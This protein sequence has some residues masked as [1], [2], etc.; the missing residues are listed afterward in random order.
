MADPALRLQR[1]AVI[2]ASGLIGR[3]LTQAL[4]RQGVEV[5][6]T[7]FSHANRDAVR[8]DISDREA[9]RRFFDQVQPQ[10][11]FLAVNTPGGVD[12]CETDFTLAERVHVLGTRN[13]AEAAAHA[14]AKTVFYSTDYIFNGQSGPYTEEA[15]P[16]PIS[17][18]GKCKLE[19]E[20]TIREAQ[21]DALILRTTAVFGWD[22]TSPNFAMQ[23]WERLQAGERIRVP[24][25]Q[26]CNPT[27]A[28]YL[29]EVSARLV[30]MGVSGIVN[31]AGR[32]RVTR[33]S[34]AEAL[35]R[36]IGLDHRLVEP[37][38][39]VALGQKALRPLE[40]GF[41]LGKL[42]Q[43]LGT[44]ALDLGASLARF[45]RQ[46]RAATH[47]RYAP[48][49]ISRE[50][51]GLRT[52][53]LEKVRQYYELVHQ[54]AEFDP[55]RSRVPYAGRVFGPEEM[56]R[57]VE[58]ALDFWLTLGPYGERF[59]QEMKRRLGVRDFALMNSGSSANLCAITAL[60]SPELDQPLRPGDEVLTPAVTF[61]TTLAP[62][63]QNSLVPV[64]VD[65]E[66]GTYNVDPEG[67]ERG[68]SPRTRAIVV[69]HT[70]GNPCDLDAVTG[71]AQRHNLYLVE[72]CCDGLGSTWRG[73]PAGTFGQLATFSFYP[74]H[75]IT[76]GEGGGVAV[77][78]GRWGRIVRSIRDWGRDCW[79]AAGESN[80]CGKRFGWQAG[81]LPSGYDHK[82]IYSH[83]GYNLKPTDLQASVGLAQLDRLDAFISAR[84]RNFDLLYSALAPYEE[85]LLR[86]R[87]LPQA[88]PSWFGFPLTVKPPVPRALLIQWLERARIETRLLF[89]GNVLRQPAFRGIRCR[90]TDSL[91]NSDTV[92]RDT[93]FIGV[94]PGL[95]EAQ[96]RYIATTF[97]EF[98][99]EFARG[100]LARAGVPD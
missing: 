41:V 60:T 61:P 63:V 79:C 48:T 89:A 8:L 64:F 1:A 14:H 20:Q 6:G 100:R 70:L 33:A 44:E 9:V 83:I 16:A 51:R 21:A 46:W 31:V 80:T 59:E 43:L 35:A 96:M 66:L 38:A 82:Y 87:W 72:D 57:L 3:Q 77:N 99:H 37:V 22:P 56:A 88:Q 76:M 11:V 45:R 4:E 55:G 74:A 19:A 81:E 5:V 90:I 30:M 39:T 54:P 58:S 15:K 71:V 7:Y 13:V 29:A 17:R 69:P 50:A 18:Y 10:V 2:G 49:G 85:W 75:H 68:I 28:E 86:P 42:E 95:G 67:I 91:Q 47:P 36:S 65:C 26:W 27:L 24:N 98:F 25:D 93:L 52:E 62:I 53:I 94:Y 34:F 40:G 84:R 23:V 92:M 97:E 78:N 73:K 32:D 12:R